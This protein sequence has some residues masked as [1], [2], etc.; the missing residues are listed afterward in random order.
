M[1]DSLR[2]LLVV[3]DERIQRLIVTRVAESIGYTVDGAADLDEAAEWLARRRYDAIVLDLS[4]GA[5]EGVSLLH[6]LRGGGADPLVVLISGIDA[7]V[8]AASC[9][10]AEALD[11]RLAGAMAKPIVP[12]TLR[13]M[14]RDVPRRAGHHV[15]GDEAADN[16]APV[17]VPSV[18]EL[19]E[20][21]ERGDITVAFQP[22]VGL[23]SRQVVGLEA[24]ARWQPAGRAPVPPDLFVPLAE[25][26]GLIAQLTRHVLRESLAA[27]RQWR[28]WHPG[29]GVAVN[30]SP[31]ML[32]NPMLPEEIEAALD[33]AGVASGALIA[34]ITE[35]AAIADPVLATEV[36]TRLRIK[37]VRLSLDDFGTGHSS[38]L[39]LMRLPFNELKI[40]RSFVTGCESDP[41]AWKI[42]RATISLAH[43]LGLDVVAEGV[44]SAVVEER[45]VGAGCDIG[46]G[47][48]FGRPMAGSAVEAWFEA[49]AA[50]ARAAAPA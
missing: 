43:E 3:D 4:L 24:L 31:L 14:L 6:M 47:W 13:A 22:K 28:D 15:P 26:H 1:T 41:E 38:L 20:A 30:I 16:A 36:L 19:A 27:C 46:Q 5:R 18:A 39:A 21:L 11:L 17:A 12:A 35:G 10:Q 40:D 2:R 49:Y 25:R 9:R 34:E 23:I 33:Q 48:R 8:R 42:I 44:E 50:G 45:L 37:G 32:A 7:R 29:C